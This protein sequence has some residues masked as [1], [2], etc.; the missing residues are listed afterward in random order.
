MLFAKHKKA[1]IG[2]SVAAVISF[3]VGTAFAAT[4]DTV[5]TPTS[6]HFDL[7]N[8]QTGTFE[9]LNT[10]INSIDVPVV[11]TVAR[12]SLIP[13]TGGIDLTNV[14][15]ETCE[16]IE[17]GRVISQG[18]YKI[19]PGTS[20]IAV[21]DYTNADVQKGSL[22]FGKKLDPKVLIGTG[23]TAAKK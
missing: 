23:L 7:T 13:V 2:L 3:G 1:I 19:E 22:I 14:Q 20:L 12:V 10:S 18:N 16:V 4:S 11:T 5:L 21:G 9:Q 8:V 15:M 17:G 6:S